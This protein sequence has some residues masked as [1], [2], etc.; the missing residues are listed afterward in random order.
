[1]LQTSMCNSEKNAVKVH[2]NLTSLLESG[3]LASWLPVCVRNTEEDLIATFL[4]LKRRQ[5]ARGGG[6]CVWQRAG[7][8]NPRRT[9]ATKC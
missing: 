1:M 8:W 5:M 3:P 9:A 6:D 7:G 2:C 4:K